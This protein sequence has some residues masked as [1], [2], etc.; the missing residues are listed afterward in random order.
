MLAKWESM[1][2]PCGKFWFI[3][4]ISSVKQLKAMTSGTHTN[5]AVK[6]EGSHTQAA[7]ILVSL[8]VVQNDQQGSQQVAHALDVTRVQM[9]PH[10]TA[11]T[12]MG[13]FEGGGGGLAG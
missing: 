12:K 4:F 9:L 1:A 6:C 8:T 10:V 11:K 7:V 13:V 5:R 3:L 2:P